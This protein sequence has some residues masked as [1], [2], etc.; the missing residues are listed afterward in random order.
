MRDMAQL[1]ALRRYSVVSHCAALFL[2]AAATTSL[3]APGPKITY[4]AGDAVLAMFPKKYTPAYPYEARRAR[5]QGRGV[6]RMYI[7]ENG[8]VT[9]IGVMKSTGYKI[10]DINA[11]Y[12]LMHWKAKP[13]HRR[14]VDMPVTFIVHW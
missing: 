1:S 10:L 3:S 13:G 11:A 9:R 2:W 8:V 14:E 7:D 6:F 5:M 4:A 12:G